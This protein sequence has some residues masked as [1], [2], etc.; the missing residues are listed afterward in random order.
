MSG[1]C[2]AARRPRLRRSA[3]RRSVSLTENRMCI[4]R[5]SRMWYARSSEMARTSWGAM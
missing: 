2:R 4:S 1:V 3:S 5:L